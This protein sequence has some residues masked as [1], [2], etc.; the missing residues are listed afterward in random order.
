MSVKDV[1]AVPGGETGRL[2]LKPVLDIE[3]H[4]VVPGYQRGYRWGPQEVRQLIKDIHGKGGGNYCLQPIVV[5]NTAS[6]W[7]LVDGQQRLTTLHLLVR[8]L[9]GEPPWTLRY[10][11]RVESANFLAEPDAERASTN[12]DFYHIWQAKQAIQAEIGAVDPASRAKMLEA[13]ANGVRVI[14]YEAPTHVS[15]IDLFTRLNS[16][17]IPLDD[18]E[19][20]KA[21]LLSQT[22]SGKIIETRDGESSRHLRANELAVQ[23]DMIERDL[24]RPEIWAFLAGSR[25]CATH[26]SLLLEIVA[27]IAPSDALGTFK[28][29]DELNKKAEKENASAVWREV[30]QLYER[31]LGWYADRDQYHR[32]G[33]LIA[34]S[35][36][37][38]RDKML[39][40]VAAQAAKR[41]HS[42]FGA[43]LKREVRRKL[44]VESSD[45]ERLRYDKDHARIQRLLVLMN[46]ET[47]SRNKHAEARY[48]FAAHH[49]DSWELEHIHAQNA[50]ELNTAKQWD[51]WVK[52]HKQAVLSL[53]T[54]AK[55]DALLQKIEQWRDASESDAAVGS[56]FRD[57]AHEI[58]TFLAGDDT[59]RSEDEVHG[60]GNLALLSKAA[61]IG[62]GNSAFEAK[63]QKIIAYDHEGDFIPACT[64]HVF[65][66]YYSEAD[67]L[68][69]HFWSAKDRAAYLKEIE[70]ILGDYLR[71]E[72]Q[73]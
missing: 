54:D 25:T 31:M 42:D 10:E 32:I 17:R 57:L 6:E 29:F 55:R 68:Q 37:D 7:E 52:V 59:A 66:K 13:L 36:A 9:G 70:K 71:D 5:K 51:A 24:R 45:L 69:P 47:T 4:F 11:T 39:R 35:G 1:S 48:P 30:M 61:N 8:A 19:L 38:G 2:C 44:N 34:Q 22:L 21:L 41:R 26:I 58:L 53:P 33:F 64:R 28:V 46:V 18:A 12:I 50:P 60:L 49:A 67:T 56:A 43:W 63:R 65:L 23:W 62:L 16:G 14:W 20:F 15:S 40:E 27:G 3:G 72:T 73:P